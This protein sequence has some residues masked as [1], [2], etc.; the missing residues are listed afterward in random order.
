MWVNFKKGRRHLWSKVP[1][2]LFCRKCGVILPI[3][4]AQ[5][6]IGIHTECLAEIN[7]RSNL[8][9]KS[10]GYGFSS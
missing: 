8:V 9:V 7:D 1:E 3:G 4:T 10:P 2:S 5:R 6:R